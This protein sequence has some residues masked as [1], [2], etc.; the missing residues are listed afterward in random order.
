MQYA[1]YAGLGEKDRVYMRP[2]KDL[3]GRDQSP[4]LREMVGAS[5]ALYRRRRWPARSER[6]AGPAYDEEVGAYLEGVAAATDCSLY[7][8]RHRRHNRG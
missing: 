4:N 6:H 2:S 1:Y 8:A 3:E 5:G 7:S